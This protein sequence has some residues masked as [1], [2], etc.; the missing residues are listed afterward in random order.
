MIDYRVLDLELQLKESEA[1]RRDKEKLIQELLEALRDYE[2]WYRVGKKR[3]QA[4]GPATG[5][6]QPIGSFWWWGQS[7]GK[8]LGKLK[9][10]ECCPRNSVT[11]GLGK[12]LQLGR[13]PT[14]II[15]IIGR[16]DDFDW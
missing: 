14:R 11:C 15:N 4:S 12:R 8:S 5:V 2:R 6:T 13:C 1:K 16:E 7:I 9:T 3:W 10:V